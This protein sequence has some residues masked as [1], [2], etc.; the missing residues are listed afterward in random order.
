MH[1]QI[2]KRCAHL[3]ETS[4]EQDVAGG[5]RRVQERGESS[6]GSRRQQETTGG[7]R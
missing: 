3:I 4:V 7:S 2:A 6:R 1:A 5:S